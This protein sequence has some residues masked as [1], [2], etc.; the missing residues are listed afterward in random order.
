M[1]F[2]YPGFFRWH[3]PALV[4]F[5]A[6]ATLFLWDVLILDYSLGAFDI[7]LNQ[8]SWKGEFSF[9]GIHQ[10]ILSDSPTAHY[11]QREFD[12]GHTRQLS[13]AEF[14]PYLFTGMPW[15]PQ[16]AGAFITS[17]PQLFLDVRNAI[18][19][20]TW[21]RLVCA[22]LFMY[23]LMLE[24]GVSRMAGIFAGILW[25]YSLHQIVWLEFPQ[26]LAAQL[27]IPLVFLFNIR[28]LENGLEAL[29]V[30]ALLV[31]NVLFFTSGYMQIVLYTYVSIGFF[32][33]VYAVLHSGRTGAAEGL[34]R[35]AGVHGVYVAAVL[36]CATGLFAEMKYIA[37]GLR[38]AQDWRGRVA[39]PSLSLESVGRLLASLFPQPS[40][41]THVLAPNYYGGI[42][43]ARY[44][45]EHGNI[46]ESA[47]Y[48]GV[49]G[50]LL[51]TA[52]LLSVWGTRHARVVAAFALVM[53]LV[54]SMFYR[55]ELSIGLLRLIPFADKGSYSRFI[56][57]LTFF[58]CV[59]AGF[60][61]HHALGD[62][63]RRLFASMA[64][65]LVFVLAA[66]LLLDEFAVSR[67]WYPA[68]LT[69][70]LAVVVIARNIMNIDWKWIGC[71]VVAA[72][73]VDLFAS[74]YGFNTRMENQRL[75][76]ENNT[77][78]YLLNDP[79]PYRVAVISD[80][81][82]YHPNILSYYDI[83]VVEGYSTV[84]PV[85]YSKY[86]D[87]LLPESHVTQNGILF[88]FE[89]NVEALRL[90]NVKYVLSDEPL[91]DEHQGLEHVVRS[92]NHSIY[93]VKNHLPRVFCASDAFFV[94]DDAGIVEE[95]GRRLDRFDEPVVMQG[96]DRH[97]R[98]DGGCR[99]DDLQVY[100]HGVSARI[101]SDRERFLV[102]PYAFSENW[103]IS[104][105]GERR[106]LR[107]ANGYHMAVR[108][109]SGSTDL[110]LLYRN[111]WNHLSAW[112]YILASLGLLAYAFRARG[113]GRVSGAVL[114]GV[115]LVII[116]K[117]SWS[118][119]LVRN[120]E[121]LE[122]APRTETREVVR[123]GASRTERE[124]HSDRIFGANVVQLPLDIESKALTRLSLLAGTFHQPRLEQPVTVQ[125]LDGGGEVLVERRIEG[126]AV[127]NNS[128]FTINFPAIEQDTE[129]YVRVA[130][131]E[132]GKSGSF[133][134]WLDPDGNVCVQSF[135]RFE[136]DTTRKP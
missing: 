55:N 41:A 67:M 46:V 89:P 118:L 20:S 101:T 48:F 33:T 42:W 28:I 85:D 17:L 27:W 82:L 59:L 62:R 72:T 131:Q 3:A 96:E 88:L 9:H 120:D 24:L 10:P 68:L 14:N 53:A 69:A 121:I 63:Y 127:R 123:Q 32:N 115:A 18:D 65:V 56:T 106:E 80:K 84:L 109:P 105:D 86:I 52:A 102:I 119:P 21:L 107:K 83:P 79:Q 87:E 134:L 74:G 12:W 110:E 76:P 97:E 133:I 94:S 37:E 61:F 34:R 5:T 1:T 103:R 92:N 23:L 112:I 50:V 40:E 30:V 124:L 126:A 136:P 58:G 132:T 38:G 116:I 43:S 71:L 128:W 15:G 13:N 64:V 77:I 130:A 111:P 91:A 8:P 108:I 104:L 26:H 90:L 75:F 22:G 113:V 4:V 99:V 73:A 2:R 98:Y 66:W 45:F 19:W 78:R 36:V 54:F 125:I 44:Q 95:Y 57:L 70:G 6:L 29:S 117:A 114:G 135:Y 31:V 100:T 16:G 122:R 49:F 60:G 11:P 25:T 39:A 93:R 51:A 7:I 35:W 81:P 47:R 129:L